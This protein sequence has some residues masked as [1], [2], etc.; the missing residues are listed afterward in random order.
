MVR[1]IAIVV[2]KRVLPGSQLVQ[3]LEKLSYSVK[4]APDPEVLPAWVKEHPPLVVMADLECRGI[5]D[6]VEQLSADAET[7]H[8]PIVGFAPDVRPDLQNRA[9][10]AGVALTIPDAVIDKHLKQFLDQALRV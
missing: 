7:K 5:Y 9:Q 10:K 6:A 8:V 2:Y 4:V 1:P 3:A